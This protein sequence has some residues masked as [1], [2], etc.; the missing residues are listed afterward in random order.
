MK[1]SQIPDYLCPQVRLMNLTPKES[2]LT[3]ST[4]STLE[5]FSNDEEDLW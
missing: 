2:V 5:G 1:N 4:V 3:T